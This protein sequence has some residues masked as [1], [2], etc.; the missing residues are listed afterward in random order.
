MDIDNI[1]LKVIG[2]GHHIKN[3]IFIDF[4]YFIQ[5]SWS[6]VTVKV[7]G[8]ISQSQIRVPEK[9]R[10]AHVN[11]KLLHLG[12]CRSQFANPP[13]RKLIMNGPLDCL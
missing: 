13:P 3:V 7:K 6:K 1:K 8:H 10:W 2:Q 5:A 11:V 9:G 12:Y 4:G